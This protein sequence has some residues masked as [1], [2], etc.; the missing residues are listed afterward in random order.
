M[1]RK[2][3]GSVSSLLTSYFTRFK[4]AR[5]FERII[6][7]LAESF[8]LSLIAHQL[9]V[10]DYSIELSLGLLSDFQRIVLRDYEGEPVSTGVILTRN[11][12]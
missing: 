12:Y 2:F 9:K 5:D 6:P 11:F 3:A 7:V 1:E 4:R 10:N 8:Q